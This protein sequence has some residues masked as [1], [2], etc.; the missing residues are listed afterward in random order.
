V[1][2]TIFILYDIFKNGNNRNNNNNDNNDNND[3]N[4]NDQVQVV[5]Q[6]NVCGSGSGSS[7]VNCQNLASQI[8]G[9]SNAVNV[10]GVQTGEED[11]SS[12]NGGQGGGQTGIIQSGTNGND[13]SDSNGDASG[14]SHRH[15]G[16]SQAIAEAN[17]CGNG[18]GAS[19]VNCQN[20]ANQVQG[21]DN[22]VNVIG[23][24][25]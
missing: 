6:A 25:Q 3:N 13:N 12:S 16:Q 11:G 2:L 22:A 4:N 24:Q 19:N 20:L 15:R 14:N 23:V 10:I 21:S 7:N 17:V 1:N 8:Q 5:S 9:D 18:A